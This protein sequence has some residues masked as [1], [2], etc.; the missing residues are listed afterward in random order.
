MPTFQ[1]FKDLSISLKPHPITGDFLVKKDVA[2]IRQS[3]SNLLYT[4]K[5]ERLFD[6]NLGTNLHSL[7]FEPLSNTTA[8][9]IKDEIV[10]VLGRY[11]PRISIEK[12]EVSAN[13]YENGF[14]V[15][16]DFVVNGR[17]DELLNLNLFL[18][19]P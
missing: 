8:G 12:I 2:A 13:L 16:L 18:E 3:V 11:E 15:R 6:S 1:T 17:D 14:N 9:L 4:K 5:T 10:E 19:R 7:L